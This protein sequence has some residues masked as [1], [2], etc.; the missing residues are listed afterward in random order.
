M[1]ISFAHVLNKKIFLLNPVPKIKYYQSKIEAVKPVI[2][3][4][5]IE[6]LQKLLS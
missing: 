6:K 2:L 4:G 5:K 1:E 3:N